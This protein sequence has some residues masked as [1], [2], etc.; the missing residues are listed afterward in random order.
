MNPTPYKLKKT[1]IRKKTF[2]CQFHQPKMQPSYI[3]VI[4]ANTNKIKKNIKKTFFE[5]VENTAEHE[6]KNRFVIVGR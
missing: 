2:K 3:H 5:N 4:T 1:K 6:L